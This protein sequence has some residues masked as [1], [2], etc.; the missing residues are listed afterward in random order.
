MPP[1]FNTYRRFSDPSAL[2]DYEQRIL[3]L[4]RQGMDWKQIAA[5]IGNVNPKSISIRYKIIQEKLA[6]QCA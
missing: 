3:D 5:A 2:T 4:R 6:A 1:R